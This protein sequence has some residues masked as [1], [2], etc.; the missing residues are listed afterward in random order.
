[1]VDYPSCL[2][3]A[4]FNSVNLVW[5]IGIEQSLWW[6]VDSRDVV[7]RSVA[8]PIVVLKH[9]QPKTFLFSHI[10]SSRRRSSSRCLKFEKELKS[11][12]LKSKVFAGGAANDASKSGGETGGDDRE[13]RKER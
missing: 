2:S 4:N 5:K 8:A 13:R 3:E 9:F 10:S 12:N 6:S 7:S 1:M 11:S